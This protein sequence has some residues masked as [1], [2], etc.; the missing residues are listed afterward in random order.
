MGIKSN[1]VGRPIEFSFGRKIE[2]KILSFGISFDKNERAQC[3]SENEK[4]I[5]AGNYK[6]WA[7]NLPVSFILDMWAVN[8]K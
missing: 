5:L 7:P 3:G 6:S 2:I 8:K 1:N 4:E